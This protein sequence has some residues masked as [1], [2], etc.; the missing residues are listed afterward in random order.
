MQTVSTLYKASIDAKKRSIQAI[1]DL[2]TGDALTDSFQGD[3]IVNIEIQRAGEQSKFFGF[4]VYHKATIKLLDKNRELNIT[5]DNYFK[6]KLGV[7][8]LGEVE[9]KRFPKFYVSEVTRDENNNE[10]TIVAFDILDKATAHTVAELGVNAPYTLKEY[11]EAAAYFLD[12]ADRSEPENHFLKL[13]GSLNS[14]IN[15]MYVP[16]INVKYWSF[17]EEG[18][19][20]LNTKSSYNGAYLAYVMLGTEEQDY[21]ELDRSKKYKFCAERISGTY[22]PSATNPITLNLDLYNGLEKDILWTSSYQE[23]ELPPVSRLSGFYIK[24]KGGIVY[25]NLTMK[26]SIVEIVD[27]EPAKPTFLDESISALSLEYPEGANIEGTE[28]LREILTAV[29]DATQTIFYVGADDAIHFRRLSDTVDKVISKD[30]YISLKGGENRSL[31]TIASVTELGDNLEATTGQPGEKQYVRDN[32]FWELREDVATLV[33]TAL[34]EMAGTSINQFECEWRGD[35]ALEPGDRIAYATK[36]DEVEYTYFLNDTLTYN[37]GLR[38]KSDWNFKDGETVST[39]L[40]NLGEVIKQT[41]AKVDKQNKEI[42]IVAGE[43]SANAQEIAALKINTESISAS[44]TKVQEANTDAI[45][46]LNGE[47]VT[48]TKK[49]ETSMTAEDVQIQIKSELSNGVDKVTTATGFT[50]NEEGLT[51]AKT[52]SEM[53]TNIDED[54][55]SVYRDNEEVLTADNTGV[56]AYNLKA[57]T[58]LIVGENSRFEDFT[59]TTGEQRT[60]CFWIGG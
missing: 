15:Y 7:E 13:D 26:F 55:M 25:S 30:I 60:G 50:F 10:L 32:P 4:G 41:Y 3:R 11:A 43:A 28:T 12:K 38:Q 17:T 31:Q 57:R 34:D 53:T 1:L 35:P 56:T 14:D 9:Y 16:N 19:L 42:E 37:G 24:N 23:W 27:E 29:A 21:I 18:Y 54:G 20:V 22:V 8:V 45:E 5:K 46:S 52:G 36:D 40:T 47:L 33:D 2:Y 6:L 48:L 51:I 39:N 59:S 49:V 44:V 58:Y